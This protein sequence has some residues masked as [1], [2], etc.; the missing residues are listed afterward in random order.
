M[1]EEEDKGATAAL[2]VES[3][4]TLSLSPKNPVELLPLLLPVM[5]LMADSLARE[6]KPVI[7][8]RVPAGRGGR[9]FMVSTEITESTS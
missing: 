4:G 8:A 5:V 9:R 2:G 7:L 3:N 1:E 6:T